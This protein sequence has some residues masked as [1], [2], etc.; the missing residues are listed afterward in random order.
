MSR[1]QKSPG[2]HVVESAGEFLVAM[3]VCIGNL[4]GGNDPIENR[5]LEA[6]GVV[7]LSTVDA[8]LELRIP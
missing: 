5:R 7:S 2:A 6:L 1:T 4:P 8:F 3:K